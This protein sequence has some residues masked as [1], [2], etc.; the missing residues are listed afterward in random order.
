MKRAIK[1]L[2][3]WFTKWVDEM[4]KYEKVCFALGGILGVFVCI[5]F[6]IFVDKI[7]ATSFDYE[8]L[9]NQAIAISKNPELLFETDCNIAVSGEITK[10][11]FENDECKLIVKYDENIEILSI[12]QV[13]KARFWLPAFGTALL[14]G[15]LAYGYGTFVF[16][17]T[18]IFFSLLWKQ[19]CKAFK[20]IKNNFFKKFKTN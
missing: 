3:N 5:M 7:P 9:E 12:T 18:F 15:G 11:V 20:S 4:E 19:I 16:V 10:I 2:I 17:Y 1:W 8:Q 14:L 6:F 13:D